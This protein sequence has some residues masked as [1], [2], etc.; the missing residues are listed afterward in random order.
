[1]GSRYNYIYD[2]DNRSFQDQFGTDNRQLSYGLS[3]TIPIY[4]G[5]QSKSQV[6]FSKVSYENAKL[7]LE[8]TEVVVKSDV[9]LAYRNFRGA[10]AGYEASASQLR[11][12]ELSYKTEKERYDLGISDI[13]QLTTS[14]QAFVR[15]QGDYQSAMF[16]LM[17]QR[18]LME[19]ALGT[20]TVDMIP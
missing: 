11:A 5:F 14:N 19:Y 3:L 10:V 12:A 1:Y 15:A 18:L 4:S 20:L 2:A 9:L 16:T 6:A 7:D 17:F 13:V 8:N